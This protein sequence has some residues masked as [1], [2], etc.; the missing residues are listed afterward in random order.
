MVK[1]G[2]ASEAVRELAEDGEDRA[3]DALLSDYTATPAGGSL[4][5]ARTPMAQTDR[6]LQVRDGWRRLSRGGALWIPFIQHGFTKN[7]HSW[8]VPVMGFARFCNLCR[9]CLVM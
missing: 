6:I 9:L 1:V 2:K 8:W 5:T 7:Y 4:R 3:T